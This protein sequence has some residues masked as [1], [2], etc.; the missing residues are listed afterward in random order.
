MFSVA[1]PPAPHTA[2]GRVRHAAPSP[3]PPAT[4]ELLLDVVPKPAPTKHPPVWTAHPAKCKIGLDGSTGGYGRIAELTLLAHA[5]SENHLDLPDAFAELFGSVPD[6]VR[7]ALEAQPSVVHL[8]R[9]QQ[10]HAEADRQH[11]LATARIAEL[12]AQRV[13]LELETPDS[14]ARKLQAIAV[15]IAEQRKRLQ[16]AEQDLATLAPLLEKARDAAE[17]VVEEAFFPVVADAKRKASE[18]RADV[19]KRISE[20]LTPLLTELASVDQALHSAQTMKGD[21]TR[22]MRQH[23]RAVPAT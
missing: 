11:R 22:Q 17:A 7:A 13:Q 19:L 18:R 21:V 3:T 16:A 14:L 4:D 6:A 9:L 20:V 1:P 10:Q 5:D 23:L 8:R 15:K 2:P 12:E